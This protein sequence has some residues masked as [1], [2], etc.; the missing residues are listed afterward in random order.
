MKKILSFFLLFSGLLLTGCKGPVYEYPFQNPALT[1]EERAADLVSR[2]T[3]D[4]KVAQMLNRTPAIERLGIKPYDWWNECLHGVAR[5]EY[6]VTVYPQAIGM[7]AGWDVDAIGRMGDYTAE[8]GRAVYNTARAKDDYRIYRGLTYWTPN[9]NIF[10][11]PRW[12]RGQETYGEDPFLTAALGVRFVEGLQGK[13]PNYLKAA[14]CAKHFAVHS[15]PEWKRHMFNVE[16]SDYDL[17]DTY[18][19]AFKALADARVA[20]FMCAYHAY[21]GQ[22]CCA[23]DGLMTE[24][25]RKEWGYEGYVTSDCGAIDD[26]YKRHHTHEGAAT[27]AVD[28][29]HH[30]TDV[31]CGREAYLALKEAVET[32]LIEEAQID[33]S[34]R[35]LFGVRLR[36]GMFDPDERVPFAA[37][38]S[39]ALERPEHKALA[40]KMAR[41]SMVLLKNNGVLPVDKGGLKKVAVVG[42]NA[43]NPE[44]QL[45][46]YNGFP[47]RIVT[48]LDGIRE[49]L[50]EGVEIYSDSVIPLY[51]PSPKTFAETIERVKD[52]DLIIYVGGIS[53]RIEG[54]EM[55][56][57]APGFYRGDRT[58]ILLPAIQTDLMKAL[59]ATGRPV[60]F[61][62][63]TG[64]AIAT[65]WESEHV[66]AIL[67]AWYGGEWAGRAIADVIFGRYNPSGRL[68]VT[69][70]AGDGDLP[71]FEDYAMDDRTYRYF[72]GRAVYPFGYGLSYTSFDYAW[73]ERPATA[74]GEKDT[75]RCVIR[76]HNSG[77]FT[78]DEVVQVYIKYPAD[79]QRLPLKELRGFARTTVLAGQTESVEVVIPVAQLA[80]WSE[81]AGRQVVFGGRYTLFAGGDS[82]NEAIVAGFDVGL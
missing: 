15:G 29:V 50:G 22:P 79:G 13:D 60:V 57:E 77:K 25:L 30:G 49:E 12:G 44:V 40:L 23:S 82:G 21:D 42:P 59:K 58:T 56:V 26:F 62:M 73:G 8:E 1:V 33:V 72:K 37:I 6:N 51:G 75:I 31:D 14:A 18:L 41:Q 48:P 81:E 4:E 74:Y 34:L 76:V 66:D 43:N 19:P 39:G 71:D 47:S 64:S 46:N 11:D 17:W 5:T 36:L 45:G 55:R 61:V 65:P 78:G 28:A 70:Y 67:N 10:R 80:K 53:P 7:A 54:E 52:A 24:I 3:L 32:G 38:D 68:P 16:V 20:G 69:F 9:I 35:R 2:L 63:M 27:A